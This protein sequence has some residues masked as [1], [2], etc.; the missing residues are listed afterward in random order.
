[1]RAEWAFADE[2]LGDALLVHEAERLL[3]R[4]TVTS[5]PKRVQSAK[6]TSKKLDQQ[7]SD[8]DKLVQKLKDEQQESPREK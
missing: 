5:A 6:K 1:M 4:A 7:A 2:E 8:L 3:A